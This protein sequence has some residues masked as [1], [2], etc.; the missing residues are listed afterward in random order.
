MTKQSSSTGFW[1]G[2]GLLALVVLG[3]GAA[4]PAKS[5]GPPPGLEQP[6]EHFTWAELT[7]SGWAA[8]NGVDNRPVSVEIYRRLARTARGILDPLVDRTPYVVFV[9]SGYRNPTVNRGVD[10]YIHSDHLTGQGLDVILY[11]QDGVALTSAEAARA[12]L[13]SQVPF[14]TLIWYG[15]DDH[16]HLSWAGAS[17]GRR[18]VQYATS[19]GATPVTRMPA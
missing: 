18:R 17:P 16:V 1:L 11:R 5:V 19:H 13:N 7:R 10:G 4:A 8:R 2:T 15:S 6:C 3:G 12:I 9:S 14:D